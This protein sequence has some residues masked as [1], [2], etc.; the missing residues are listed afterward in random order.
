MRIELGE[1][2]PIKRPQCHIENP[3]ETDYCGKYAA[4]LKSSEAVNISRIKILHVPM[5]EL[6]LGG[7]FVGRYQIL[8]ELG[9]VK[10]SE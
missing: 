10:K 2:M 1:D 8:E 4:P 6:A 9:I 3:A 7:T 5:K